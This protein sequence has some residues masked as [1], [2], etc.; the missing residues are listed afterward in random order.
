VGDAKGGGLA[1]LDPLAQQPP[2]YFVDE[3]WLLRVLNAGFGE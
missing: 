3:R 2:L 1:T